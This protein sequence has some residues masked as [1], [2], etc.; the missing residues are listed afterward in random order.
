MIAM[1]ENGVIPDPDNMNS[2]GIRWLF[3]NTW[4]REFIVD[5]SGDI[6]E[7]YTEKT[8][9]RKVYSHPDIVTLEDLPKFD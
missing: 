4:C 9:L 2:D 1:T 3:F 7:E 5:R 6:S 8:M